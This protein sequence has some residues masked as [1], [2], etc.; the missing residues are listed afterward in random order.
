MWIKTATG[1]LLN[2]EHVMSIDYVDGYTRVMLSDSKI[3][4]ISEYDVTQ[5]IAT[6]IMNNKTFV[7]VH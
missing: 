4:I 3:Y 1:E 7:G 5:I 6:A 2:T